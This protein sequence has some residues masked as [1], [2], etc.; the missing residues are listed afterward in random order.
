MK[1]GS[2]EVMISTVMLFYIS[3]KGNSCEII[4]I[5]WVL[6]FVDSMGAIGPQICILNEMLIF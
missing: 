4:N 2:Q 1:C 6:I 3:M 5:H